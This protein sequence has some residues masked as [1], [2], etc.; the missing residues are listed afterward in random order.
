MMRKISMEK[1]NCAFICDPYS[2][3]VQATNFNGF[4][5]SFKTKMYL[6]WEDYYRCYTHFWMAG[7][8]AKFC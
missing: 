4:H 1:L 3:T 7:E 5:S 6:A 2:S 8:I